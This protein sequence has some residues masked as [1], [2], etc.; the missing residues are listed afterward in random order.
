MNTKAILTIF[1]IGCILSAT[2]N[3]NKLW[4]E[5]SSEEYISDEYVSEEH[6]CEEHNNLESTSADQSRCKNWRTNK[7]V[8]LSGKYLRDIKISFHPKCILII[9]FFNFP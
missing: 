5:H 7:F 4:N 2:G 8:I 3:E 6:T 1:L 9:F